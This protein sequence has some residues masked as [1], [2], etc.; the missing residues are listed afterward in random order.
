MT[1]DGTRKKS[2][3]QER[4]GARQSVSKPQQIHRTGQAG[5][6]LAQYENNLG[7]LYR[8]WRDEVALPQNI[9][10]PS[11]NE[12]V[13]QTREHYRTRG[14]DT[15]SSTKFT[16][17]LLSQ[18]GL[19]R[20]RFST[21][22]SARLK[23]KR[24]EKEMREKITQDRDK[25]EKSYK[26]WFEQNDES[27]IKSLPEQ[28]KS[29]I[30]IFSPHL[31]EDA[32]QEDSERSRE[33]GAEKKADM[34]EY[35]AKK[36]DGDLLL[37]YIEKYIQE[38]QEIRKEKKTSVDKSLEGG[39]SEKYKAWGDKI[40]DK[41]MEK[42]RREGEEARSGTIPLGLVNNPKHFH[43]MMRED[44]ESSLYSVDG[45]EFI[46]PHIIK[47]IDS[48]LPK[49]RDGNP[50]FYSQKDVDPF[51]ITPGVKVNDPFVDQSNKEVTID[52]LSLPVTPIETISPEVQVESP[53]VGGLPGKPVDFTSR[54]KGTGTE[55][56]PGKRIDFTRDE[57]VGTV[58][59]P[60]R[61]IPLSEGQDL[62][63]ADISELP[64]RPVAIPRVEVPTAAPPTAEEHIE[65]EKSEELKNIIARQEFQED[66]IA[67]EWPSYEDSEQDFKKWKAI[68][69]K[70]DWGEGSE[71][72]SKG[73]FRL[74][75]KELN[76]EGEIM[77]LNMELV[78]GETLD[79]PM[80]DRITDLLRY[81]YDG[82]IK[83]LKTE[84]K[85]LY[86]KKDE[87][88][89][90]YIEE[91][92]HSYE[93]YK[94]NKIAAKGHIPNFEYDPFRKSKEVSIAREVNARHPIGSLGSRSKSVGN[95][96][97]RQPNAPVF[98]GGAAPDV[99]VNPGFDYAG[100]LK[101]NA[102]KERIAKAK[103]IKK[104]G[105]PAIADALKNDKLDPGALK[106]AAAIIQQQ[107]GGAVPAS[108]ERNI[109]EENEAHQRYVA[110]FK[111]DNVKA[112]NKLK[113][114]EQETIFK[115]WQKNQHSEFRKLEVHDQYTELYRQIEQGKVDSKGASIAP[116]RFSDKDIKE[117]E[118]LQQTK[119]DP[120]WPAVDGIPVERDQFGNPVG[121]RAD[122]H[123][124]DPTSQSLSERNGAFKEWV[125][126]SEDYKKIE[127]I[128]DS[129][130]TPSVG[131]NEVLNKVLLADGLIPNLA[132]SLEAE[133][134]IPNLA[135]TEIESIPKFHDGGIVPNYNVDSKGE[136]LAKLLPGEMVIPR[137]GVKSLST[138]ARMMGAGKKV[139]KNLAQ[140]I[141]SFVP[142]YYP[143]EQIRD[144]W[145]PILNSSGEIKGGSFMAIGE[146]PDGTLLQRTWD[147]VLTNYKDS[148]HSLAGAKKIS[149]ADPGWAYFWNL[150][151]SAISPEELEMENQWREN[152]PDEYEAKK[153][154]VIAEHGDFTQKAPLVPEYIVP[155]EPGGPMNARAD[156]QTIEQTRIALGD[157]VNVVGV[158][159]TSKHSY[160]DLLASGT[161]GF[162]NLSKTHTVLQDIG[163]SSARADVT[164]LGP[165]PAGSYSKDQFVKLYK[166]RVFDG[167]RHII[168]DHFADA[169]KEGKI[170]KWTGGGT[171][172]AAFDLNAG[173]IMV[174]NEAASQVENALSGWYD[175]TGGKVKP[176]EITSFIDKWSEWAAEKQT[177]A[178]Q[179]IDLEVGGFNVDK[180]DPEQ[181]KQITALREQWAHAEG[182][183]ELM[184]KAW[185][186]GH[187]WKH[188]E[189]GE[190]MMPEKE[191]LSW[192]EVG[193]EGSEKVWK[194]QEGGRPAI[195]A[196]K[197]T[198][199]EFTKVYSPNE[200]EVRVGA[201]KQD[202]L[203]DHQVR[204]IREMRKVQTPLIVN[205]QIEKFLAQ[206]EI[207]DTATKLAGIGDTISAGKLV[208]D[209]VEAAPRQTVLQQF[210]DFPEDLLTD[211]MA[212]QILAANPRN[213]ALMANK[214]KREALR[215][216]TFSTS[217]SKIG[218]TPRVRP[219]VGPS[220][221]PKFRAGG[222]V[223]NFADKITA[224]QRVP[225]FADTEARKSLTVED[226]SKYRI[227]FDNQE[228]IARW[229]QKFPFLLVRG[230]DEDLESPDE[231]SPWTPE[232][233]E[234]FKE[235][236][237]RQAEAGMFERD[238]LPLI[239][240]RVF[241]QTGFQSKA[242][243]GS[244]EEDKDVG[245][246]LLGMRRKKEGDPARLKDKD[247]I[248]VE[249]IERDAQNR[250]SVYKKAEEVIRKNPQNPDLQ[251][252]EKIAT[253]ILGPEEGKKVSTTIQQDTTT[254]N[255]SVK[256][257]NIPLVLLGAMGLG[258]VGNKIANMAR[259]RKNEKA[260]K[261]MLKEDGSLSP[262][263]DKV[264]DFLK[265][266][267][268]MEYIDSMSPQEIKALHLETFED[269]G[270]M[271]KEEK[272]AKTSFETGDKLEPGK[273]VHSDFIE[274]AREL[275][276]KE[277]S[278]R[279]GIDPE[280]KPLPD[281]RNE[282]NTIAGEKG[283]KE[284]VSTARRKLE[285]RKSL[286]G[287][288]ADSVT[289]RMAER[290]SKGDISF[291]TRKFPK[292]V[293]LR[294]VTPK[295]FPVSPATALE[296]QKTHSERVDSLEQSI[297]DRQTATL[298][299]IT[300]S[301]ETQ[302]TKK[303]SAGEVK[304]PPVEEVIKSS[305]VKFDEEATRALEVVWSESKKEVKGTEKMSADEFITSRKEFIKELEVIR[306]KQGGTPAEVEKQKALTLESD[307]VKSL[308]Q[309]TNP[310]RYGSGTADKPL[311]KSVFTRLKKGVKK[312]LT[313]T[314]KKTLVAPE[315]DLRANLEKLKKED[316]DR[317][318]KLDP[319]YTKLPRVTPRL[320]LR[321]KGFIPN[322]ISLT[323]GQHGLGCTYHPRKQ[324]GIS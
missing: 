252:I 26:E 82:P 189:F 95:S 166:G 6:G 239:E 12:M 193:P 310:K 282:I 249:D 75:S 60:G 150:P 55:G 177:K 78:P 259:N 240:E 30:D 117:L 92:V 197:T 304:I 280:G 190:G 283:G 151:L 13:E 248:T 9:Q 217:P 324:P 174:S 96:T 45:G 213:Q 234:T 211:D 236:F 208:E 243:R 198:G 237:W 265:T 233:V 275:E 127:G 130:E 129:V 306:D 153:K 101:S 273:H 24:E 271:T 34:M 43:Q 142:N 300:E 105:G 179:I 83:E 116:L 89:N 215:N 245:R 143:L 251:A 155:D 226:F 317:F 140:E 292:S 258:V 44:I 262:R 35:F 264:A 32:M 50:S 291:T 3:Q 138:K 268:G 68:Q 227:D 67:G 5:S 202:R 46:A 58:G 14:T 23:I 109:Q 84:D 149:N 121:Y 254:S 148:W 309:K 165:T 57:T 28:I 221:Y 86:F 323:R 176:E 277:L 299:D 183:P 77:G 61:R 169:H 25:K 47:Y 316:P 286:T 76:E 167:M 235:R 293:L 294:T 137:E 156:L 65:K 11:W 246:A 225:N 94:I 171:G 182:D 136:V 232:Q 22:L 40:R 269:L 7:P 231:D 178:Y 147:D 319:S 201:T 56:L 93:D 256:G 146:M 53:K 186:E 204:Q 74:A 209:V 88:L 154:K 289:T 134:M 307:E 8:K 297:I 281:L 321:A 191:Q 173:N 222:F 181:A 90:K 303:S 152:S 224:Q 287:S 73:T 196:D 253:Q 188:L 49:D 194:L 168:T 284:R 219:P 295:T 124:K 220:K 111:G 313:A 79:I 120:T 144:E 70:S 145:R 288:D 160:R 107:Q 91:E 110:Q 112:F 31:Y 285:I 100:G 52:P 115:K 36:P 69:L 314:A 1:L 298:S 118:A 244:T 315:S 185:A 87:D 159:D 312:P 38:K 308:A 272:A 10:A 229:T 170:E 104:R 242:E 266:P 261:K 132:Q 322:F 203:Y 278:T 301:L 241:N 72:R 48:T 230:D 62:R 223:P 157:R 290:M 207:A 206:N 210:P 263:G 161:G 42:N 66:I 135:T 114:V 187:A 212:K 80:S 85:S 54:A 122:F 296:L 274:K 106:A 200:G 218:A 39:L 20:K 255:E 29:E 71:R 98:L 19:N 119:P 37:P 4:S 163:G 15:A 276:L 279:L 247:V 305:G 63:P 162:E 133:G 184:K 214:L 108:G 123:P 125:P 102:E 192:R 2:T 318:K 113:G 103:E 228:N 164:A 216:E 41:W 51:E 21:E 257:V 27:A 128:T 199:E 17:S 97:Q 205:S 64:G 131:I 139:P 260:A 126:I 59:L 238:Q 18:A 99:V 270:E 33:W 158:T 175:T 250:Q 302:E 320:K 311:Q 172:A 195:F 16:G 81:G 141:S 267:Q 180:M